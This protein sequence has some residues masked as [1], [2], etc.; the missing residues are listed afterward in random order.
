MQGLWGDLERTGG[1]IH[2]RSDYGCVRVTRIYTICVGE[3]F[4]L[5]GVPSQKP[6]PLVGRKPPPFPPPQTRP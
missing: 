4:M 3:R 5:I 2:L 6:N 1:A